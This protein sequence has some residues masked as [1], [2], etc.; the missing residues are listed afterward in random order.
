MLISF[1]A[2]CEKY[3]FI[4]K[5]ILHIGAHEL[6]EMESYLSLGVNNIIW[7]EGNQDLVDKNSFRISGTDQILISSVVYS[8]DDLDMDFNITNNMQSSSLLEFDKHRNYHPSVSVEK[9][10][11]VKTSR[12]DTILEKNK[13]VKDSF[14]FVNLDIQGVEMKALLGFGKY[15]D[16]V[17]YIY[18]EINTGSV[19]KNND[20]LEDLDKFLQNLMFKRVETSMTEYEWGDAFYIR[21]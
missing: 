9:K 11:R 15:M 13:I 12:V 14:D 16:Q 4:P 10:I 19:Y 6:E 7:V 18:T 20:L 3:E 8:E 2:L 1:R 5:G 17:K 21:D